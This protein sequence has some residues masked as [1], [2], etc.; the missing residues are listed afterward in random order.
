[1]FL[2]DGY[3]KTE[4]VQSP[5]PTFQLTVFNVF[6]GLRCLPELVIVE[7]DLTLVDARVR[8]VEPDMHRGKRHIGE[9]GGGEG[10]RGGGLGYSYGASS[11]RFRGSRFGICLEGLLDLYVV[12]CGKPA[13]GRCGAGVRTRQ[14]LAGGVEGAEKCL[15]AQDGT[16]VSIEGREAAWF[17]VYG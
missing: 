14:E 2:I 10:G 6:W 9:P 11:F 13:R 15:K 3:L 4:S 5:T 17:R 12:V 1:M 16:I 7:L 8:L